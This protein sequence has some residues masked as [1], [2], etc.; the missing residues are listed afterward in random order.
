MPLFNPPQRIDERF[1]YPVR[2][3]TD[4]GATYSAYYIGERRFGSD[5]LAYVFVT[6]D[7]AALSM[8]DGAIREAMITAPNLDSVVFLEPPPVGRE[9]TKIE[10]SGRDVLVGGENIRLQIE[11]VCGHTPPSD[12]EIALT[13]LPPSYATHIKIE[14]TFPRDSYL[15]RVLIVNEL[16]RLGIWGMCTFKFVLGS[17]RL[18]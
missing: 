2:L 7:K 15:A 9:P 6:N 10:Y 3:T 1:G 8:S 14:C 13:T 18:W 12:I 16:K 4:K 11:Q 5:P 17:M